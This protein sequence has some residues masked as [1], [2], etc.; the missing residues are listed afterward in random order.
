MF[1]KEQNQAELEDQLLH[2]WYAE[3]TAGHN[4]LIYFDLSG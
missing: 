3:Q 4:C 2:S 1:H